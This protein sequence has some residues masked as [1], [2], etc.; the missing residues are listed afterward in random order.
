MWWLAID[1]G[2][3][4][5]QAYRCSTLVP[6]DACHVLVTL[7]VRLCHDTDGS[8]YQLLAWQALVKFFFRQVVRIYC[9]NMN[10]WLAHVPALGVQGARVLV[11][12]RAPFLAASARARA[13]ARVHALYCP[14]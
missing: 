13:R 11:S 2:S 7:H 12:A 4:V 1:A 9:W 14:Q 3:S 8:R 5:E 6:A 10:A